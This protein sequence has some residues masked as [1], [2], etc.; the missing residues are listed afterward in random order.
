MKRLCTVC[1][2][3]GS[4]GLPG[5]NIKPL[6]GKPLIAW[7]I[8]QAR[9]AGIF[10]VIA[11][12]SDDAAILQAARTAG[13]DLL[14][15]RPAELASDASAKVPAIEQAVR[16]AE[17]ETEITFDTLVDLDATS[18]LRLPEDIV[19]AVRML[20]ES[21]RT[22]I[23]TGCV[24]RHSPFFNLVEEGV[25]GNVTLSKPSNT[26][27]RQDAPPSYDMNASIYA[28][29]RNEF[30]NNPQVFYQ[31]TGIYVMPQERSHDIDSEFDFRVVELML[32]ERISASTRKRFNL[33]GKVAVITGATGILGRRF[34]SVL[35]EHGADIA[36]IDLS[37]SDSLAADLA[38]T[39]GIQARGYQ[40]D[41][42]SPEEC[43]AVIAEV[44]K[45]LGP[46]DILHNN[47][48]SKGPEL[49]RFFDPVE[50]FSPEIWRSIM[51]V[52][53]NGYFYMAQAVG[54][55]MAERG[56]GVIVQTS[57]IYGIVGPDQRIY[58]DSEYLGM[59]INTPAIYSASKAGVVGLSKYLATYW[60]PRGIRV[61]TLT[62]GGVDSGQNAEFSRRYST[63]VP[64]G[65][66]ASPDDIAFALLYLVSDEAR[67]VT[68][69]NLVVDGGLTAW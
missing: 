22:N 10:D 27:R 7:T 53:L 44:E 32:G 11:V 9:E 16:Q 66:M 8:E 23:I 51:E 64:L 60:G 34:C 12:S 14:I 63:R 4:K 43:S 37:A 54:P 24:A 42:S 26:K 69:H 21:D 6:H 62:P 13:A 5:K 49:A 19:A 47:A 41:I 57:S 40:A 1:A 35:A 45:H 38:Q 3:G 15:T 39:Y 52:N 56:K 58:E 46:I 48:A 59:P 33:T 50:T 30:L 31:D 36:V 65:R 2:R 20:E 61:N 55:R 28:W 25:D 67:Y 18:P 29:R 17:R 68:G